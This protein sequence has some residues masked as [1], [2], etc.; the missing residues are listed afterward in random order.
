M[1]SGVLCALTIVSSHGT[2]N[3]CRMSS[4]AFM[5]GRSESEPIMMPTWGTGARATR[6]QCPGKQQHQCSSGVSVFQGMGCLTTFKR[7]PAADMRCQH[8]CCSTRCSCGTQSSYTRSSKAPSCTEAQ[9]SCTATFFQPA[10]A[11]TMVEAEFRG[12]VHPTVTPFTLGALPLLPAPAPDAAAACTPRLP[13]CW[14]L[15]LLLL[16][17]APADDRPAGPLA[18]DWLLLPALAAAAEMMPACCAAASDRLQDSSSDG[19]GNRADK[20]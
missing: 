12:A 8:V 6:K 16:P 2:P 10:L 9:Y 13:A 11:V 3:S 17:P 19:I 15:P 5:V 14:L 18:P 4:A 1:R 20:G 7:S